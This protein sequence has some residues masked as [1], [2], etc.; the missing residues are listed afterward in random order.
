MKK[1]LEFFLFIVVISSCQK[2]ATPVPA[3]NTENNKTVGTSAAQPCT[4]NTWSLTS[5]WPFSTGPT[6]IHYIGLKF[7]C[8]NKLYVPVYGDRMYIYD[9]SSWTWVT[10]VLPLDYFPY[11]YCFSVND[12]GYILALGTTYKTLWQYDP[13]TNTWAQKASFTGPRRFEGVSFTIGNKA[14]ISSGRYS[15]TYYKDLWQYDP[16]SDQWNQKASMPSGIPGRARA[17]AFSIGSNGYV[18]GGGSDYT[19]YNGPNVYYNTVLGYNQILNTWSV[20]ATYPGILADDAAS[21]A[22][23]NYGYAGLDKHN[24]YRYSPATNAWSAIAAYPGEEYRHNYGTSYNSKGYVLS[25]IDMYR[26]NPQVCGGGG[27][28]P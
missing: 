25:S 20:L 14:Y 13:I 21:F 15:D 9:G 24:F 2:Q 4:G 5:G 19:P 10:S 23:G 27:T 11:P 7:V 17:T 22:A 16:V 26:Y 28:T 12:K 1:Y 3:P 8:G 18:V 6:D